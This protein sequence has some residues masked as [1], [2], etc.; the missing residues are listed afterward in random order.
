M[1][2]GLVGFVVLCAALFAA[3]FVVQRHRMQRLAAAGGRGMG[4][5]GNLG[6]TGGGEGKDVYMLQDAAYALARRG[7]WGAGSQYGQ[8]KE[9]LRAKRYRE[10]V[11]RSEIE[12]GVGGMREE[13][14]GGESARMWVG[15]EVG[16][17]KDMSRSMGGKGEGY[18]AVRRSDSEFR[19]MDGDGEAEDSPKFS[20]STHRTPEPAAPT[21][22]A[23]VCAGSAV[24]VPQCEC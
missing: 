1:L 16:K 7:S 8:S 2:I 22:G 5:S 6:G 14:M 24:A 19:S 13:S 10:Y 9:T 11:R 20:M 17:G 23:R 15:E 3:C 18:E 12:M 21:E 4:S